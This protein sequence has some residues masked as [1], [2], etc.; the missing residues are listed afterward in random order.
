M[1]LE[2][3]LS[4]CR[5]LLSSA[6]EQGGIAVDATAGNGHDTA[7]LAE[8]VGDGGHV[9]GFDIQEEA[10]ANTAE[11]LEKAGLTARTTLFKESHDTISQHIPS[12]YHG[13]IS[14]AVFN[15]GYLP[16]G[17]KGIVTVPSSTIAAVEQLLTLLKPQG[18]IVL[19]IY[20]GHPQGQEEK[21]A[22]MQFAEGIDQNDAHV[23]KYQYLN[24]K[25][26]APFLI[27]IEKR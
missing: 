27:A 5:S 17:N 23:L 6:V 16:G 26:N 2:R 22:V 25:N 1:K 12:V 7:F 15:L 19:V 14:A 4:F 10:I 20:H 13:K 11:R 9:Y 3:I 24:Q 18:I 21:N 8:C